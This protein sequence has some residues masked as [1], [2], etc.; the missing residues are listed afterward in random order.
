MLAPGRPGCA[1]SDGLR[2]ALWSGPQG[3]LREH[4]PMALASGCAQTS[5]LK[6]GL[7]QPTMLKIRLTISRNLPRR[8]LASPSVSGNLG[9]AQKC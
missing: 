8:G 7:T 4:A 3:N 5:I 1:G 9:P 2:R 6:M